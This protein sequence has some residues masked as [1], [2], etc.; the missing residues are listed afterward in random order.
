MLRIGLTGGI[1]SGKSTICKWFKERGFLV[2]DADQVAHQLIRKGQICFKPIINLFGK[3][4]LD[5]TG[6]IDRKSLG[7][8]VFNN[9]VCLKQ[10]NEL[11][12]PQVTKK[13]L[14]QLKNLE[15]LEPQTQ[16]IVDASLMVES[17]FYKQFS[18][19]IVVSCRLEQQVERLIKRSHLSISQAR[20]RIALQIPL[21][22]KLLYATFVIDNSGTLEQTHWQ[23]NEIIN[24]ICL[25]NQR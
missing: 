9:V 3:G 25:R 16:V 14:Q 23:V 22:E 1:S 5:S 19:L 15:K 10:L 7:N 21:K 4:I 13:I 6:E 20:D 2:I 17:G 18:D 24:S 11:V 12:H 8:L